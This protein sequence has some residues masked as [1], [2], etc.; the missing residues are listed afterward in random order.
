MCTLTPCGRERGPEAGQERRDVAGEAGRRRRAQQLRRGSVEPVDVEHQR[1]ARRQ[2][3]LER[4]RERERVRP[5]RRARRPRSSALWICTCAPPV[6]ADSE[7]AVPSSDGRSSSVAIAPATPPRGSSSAAHPGGR[8][9]G[10]EHAAG[11]LAGGGPLDTPDRPRATARG[12]CRRRSRRGP[13]ASG[14]DHEV[15]ADE[16]ELGSRR[17]AEDPDARRRP[18]PAPRRRGSGTAAPARGWRRRARAA[19]EP[20]RP[21]CR[22]ARAPP[23]C[24]AT[25]GCRSRSRPSSSRRRRSRSAG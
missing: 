18:R 25:D 2:H 9:V 12:P 4:R 13:P 1:R 23:P 3:R 20:T 22:A 19:T 14:T 16:R 15:V 17:V 8:D 5:A 7:I 21:A 24:R 10:V 11:R 6:T